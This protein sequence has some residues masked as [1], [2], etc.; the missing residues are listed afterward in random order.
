MNA[1]DSRGAP[2]DPAPATSQ[3]PLGSPFRLDEVEAYLRWREQK[4]RGYPTHIDEL[5]VEIEDPA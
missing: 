5:V 3:G 1:N 4:L 2:V